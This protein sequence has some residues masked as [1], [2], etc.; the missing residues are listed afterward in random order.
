MPSVAK[1]ESRCPSSHNLRK[2]NKMQI[3]ERESVAA[4]GKKSQAG[5]NVTDNMCRFGEPE[6]GTRGPV[7]FCAR[8]GAVL[9]CSCRAQAKNSEEHLTANLNDNQKLQRDLKPIARR[10]VN[11]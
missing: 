7:V 9:C 11:P 8:P 1:F 4:I 3:S 6:N 10:L 5:Q 2:I